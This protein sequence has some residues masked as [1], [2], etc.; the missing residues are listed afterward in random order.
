[1]AKINAADGKWRDFP[2]SG[3]FPACGVLAP[4]VAFCSVVEGGEAMIS[5]C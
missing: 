3:V 5:M 4:V 1:M 2:S